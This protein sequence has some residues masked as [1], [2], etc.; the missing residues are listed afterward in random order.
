VPAGLI[1]SST[2]PPGAYASIGHVSAGQTAITYDPTN[3]T[4]GG[5]RFSA[6]LTTKSTL[7]LDHIESLIPGSDPVGPRTVNDVTLKPKFGTDTGLVVQSAT[8]AFTGNDVGRALTSTGSALP[9]GEV[10]KSVTDATHANMS[11][12]FASVA[13]ADGVVVT[14]SLNQITSATAGFTAADATNHTPVA[15]GVLAGTVINAVSGNT[16]TLSNS[17]AKAGTGVKL[18]IGRV[19]S[20]QNL[21]IGRDVNSSGSIA[22]KWVNDK[23][24]V[25]EP[26]SFLPTYPAVTVGEKRKIPL[27]DTYTVATPAA[28]TFAKTAATDPGGS[29]AK[30]TYG[31]TTGTIQDGS[32]GVPTDN[33]FNLHTPAAANEVDQLVIAK[34]VTGGDYRLSQAF[35]PLGDISTGDIAFNATNTAIKSA[36]VAGA[37]TP[38][39]AGALTAGLIVGAGTVDPAGNTRF[40]ITYG[41]VQSNLAGLNVATTAADGVTTPLTPDNAIIATANFANSA[42]VG[43][44]DPGASIVASPAPGVYEGG[45]AFSHRKLGNTDDTQALFVSYPAGVVP[46]LSG[47]GVALLIAS[48][49]LQTIAPLFT[50]NTDPCGVVGLLALFCEQNANGLG[51]DFAG[52]C[53]ANGGPLP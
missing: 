4:S 18:T 19:A 26:T 12:P 28:L 43:G 37:S 11:L 10:I 29:G 3:N 24:S 39:L 42:Q 1:G 17:F 38:T 31:A 7:A 46:D 30:P 5:I 22:I 36:M 35:G 33:P 34:D 40:T 23:G 48:G 15:G 6:S 41:F 21:T 20:S 51:P 50:I 52:F 13:I 14:G 25:A 8:A 2:L 16:A 49:V 44:T 27:N 47:P 9:V 45:W 32:S 53:T